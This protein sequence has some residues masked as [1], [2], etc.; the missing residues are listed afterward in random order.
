[1]SD[2]VR[3]PQRAVKRF[4]YLLTASAVDRVS[5]DDDKI[6]SCRKMI[7]MIPPAFSQ[8]SSGSVPLNAVSYLLACQISGSVVIQSV[9]HKKQ[10]DIAFPDG[11][12]SPVDSAKV[13]S[14]S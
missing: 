1:M 14:V 13:I 10:Y 3:L 5:G 2:H 8:Q 11:F 6:I 9:F 4:L 12:P 7:P